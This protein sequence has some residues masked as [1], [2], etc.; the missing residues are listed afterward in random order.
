MS[1][2]IHSDLKSK[3]IL[4]NG[5][6]DAAKCANLHGHGILYCDG[7]K[8]CRFHVKGV[9]VDAIHVH[10]LALYVQLSITS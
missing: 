4:L 8:L 6:H 7:M 1:Q 5:S 10:I 2:V 9:V 3:N